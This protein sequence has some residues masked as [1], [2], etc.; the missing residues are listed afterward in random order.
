MHNILLL[1]SQQLLLIKPSDRSVF[2][3]VSRCCEKTMEVMRSSQEALLTIVEVR[4]LAAHTSVNEV[5]MRKLGDETHFHVC[6]V[7]GGQR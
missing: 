6:C 2:L 1:Q 7:G 3:A 5:A 4:R